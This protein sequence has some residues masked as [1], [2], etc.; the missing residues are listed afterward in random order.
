MLEFNVDLLITT[1]FELKNNAAAL[2]WS[3]LFINSLE[4]RGE[5][6]ISPADTCFDHV[7]F[8]AH[9]WLTCVRSVSFSST[10]D[11]RVGSYSWA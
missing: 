2:I 10:C 9:K 11:R 6:S 3:V 8:R 4:F 1:S 5:M 7:L